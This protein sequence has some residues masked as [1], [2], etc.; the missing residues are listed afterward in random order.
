MK[1]FFKWLAGVFAAFALFIITILIILNIFLDTEPIITDNSYL[2]IYL[3]GEIPEYVPP[4]PL[5][6]ALGRKPLDIKKIRDVLEKARVDDRINGVIIRPRYLQIG[7]AKIQELRDLI[8]EYRKS[9]KKAYAFLDADMTFGKGYYV[10][11]A[12]DSI[13]MPP[14]ANLFLSGVGAEV[15]FYKGFFDKIGV[16]AE[17]INIGDYKNAP[18]RYTRETIAPEQR[19]ELQKL[20]DAFY[21]DMILTISASR[22]LPSQDLENLIN[23]KTGF[24]GVEAISSGLVD[25]T[26]YLNDVV[27]KL[28]IHDRKPAQLDAEEYARVPAS[29]LDIRDKSRIAVVYCTGTIAGGSDSDDPLLGKLSGAATLISNLN[30]AAR[31]SLNKAIILR[32]DSPGGSAVASEM[33]EHAVR[34]AAGKKPLVVSVSDYGASGGYYIAMPGDTLIAA[35]ASVVGSIGIYAGKF[36]VKN[37]YQKLNLNTAMISRGENAGMFSLTESWTA[38][39][40]A[41]IKRL[42]QSY[43]DD[44]LKKVSETRNLPVADVREIAG[45]RVYTGTEAVE[46]GLFDATGTFYTAVEAAKHLA[47]IDAAESVRLVYF[48]RRKSFFQEIL[49]N[50]KTMA[51]VS[52]NIDQ[53]YV[54]KIIR[55]LNSIQNKPMARLPYIIDWR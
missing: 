39:E 20:I 50:V 25:N 29:S 51:S 41:I 47:G 22:D 32:I 1:A 34:E 14:S 18:D 30:K 43:Y 11:T 12:C 38:A 27:E 15:T 19:R 13:F 6:E 3:S 45:G 44:W 24:S 5:E 23:E 40:Q 53:L 33:I 9:G 17:F 4:D 46:N 2:N 10:A 42:I 36:N 26:A 48:P 55:Y 16:E 37:L 35:P 54:D 49:S 28:K 21:D 7:F 31:S 8:L 52:G